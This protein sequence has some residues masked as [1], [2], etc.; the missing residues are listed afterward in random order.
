M[1]DSYMLDASWILFGLWSV[2]VAAVSVAAFGRD[3]LPFRA[4]I[5]SPQN[6]QT[7]DPARSG[8]ANAG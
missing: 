8:G 4:Q 2:I 5:N 1:S 3:L 6:A 7:T